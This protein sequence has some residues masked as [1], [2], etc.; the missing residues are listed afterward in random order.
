MRSVSRT[1]RAITE[2]RLLCDKFYI[3]Q[4]D[5][6]N[7]RCHSQPITQL[8]RPLAT[9]VIAQYQTVFICVPGFVWIVRPIA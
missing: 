2:E 5:S 7:R 8:P 1:Q 4:S 6:T 3:T 9:Q